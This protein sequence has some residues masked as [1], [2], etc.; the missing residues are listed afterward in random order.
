MLN[1]DNTSQAQ[2]LGYGNKQWT[3]AKTRAGKLGGEVDA[4]FKGLLKAYDSGDQ[5]AIQKADIMLKQSLAR[6]EAFSQAFKAWFDTIM[7]IIRKI[8]V[9]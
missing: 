6:L 3:D 8:D 2:S 1:T 7:S 9:R 4:A 5:K